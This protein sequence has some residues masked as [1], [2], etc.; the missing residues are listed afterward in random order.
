MEIRNY[1]DIKI[2]EKKSF[3]KTISEADIF[4][5]CGITG[6][7]NPM[8]VD[9]VFASRTRFKGRIAHG[10]LVA[11][12]VD[13]TLTAIM[14]QGGIHVS[15]Q[16]AFKAPVKI[17]DTITVT[18]EVNEKVVE[19]RRVFITSTWVNQEDITVITGKSE[20]FLPG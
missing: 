2:G 11:G 20:G 5:F 3:S 10:M 4:A 9:E 14:G 19:K 18:S 7:F 13:Q 17:G 16:V 1:D 12:L 8:H 6:D 15:Q